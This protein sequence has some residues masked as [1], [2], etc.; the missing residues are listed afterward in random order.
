M[1]NAMGNKAKQF[2]RGRV[3]GR[4]YTAEALEVRRL[5][6]SINPEFRVNSFVDFPQYMP[7]LAGD[8]DGDF[9]V[10]WQSDGQIQGGDIYARR[11]S[12]LG[13]EL[14]PPPEVP[15]AGLEN[16]FRVNTTFTGNQN[17][18]AVAMDPDGDF[19]VA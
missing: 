2:G 1:G 15:R 12:R 18:P 11:Y 9:V 7:A 14:A 13:P 5:F 16:D 3:W 17:K 19:V 8:A 6:G 10:V 4:S